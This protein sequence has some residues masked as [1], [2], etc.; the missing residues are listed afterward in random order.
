MNNP[1]DYVDGY[2]NIHG[3]YYDGYY[4]Y[5]GVYYDGY[6]GDY[7]YFAYAPSQARVSIGFATASS[8]VVSAPEAPVRI[9]GDF[10][11]TPLF[12]TINSTTNR[13]GAV[14]FTAPDNVGTFV[15]QVYGATGEHH[16]LIF[17]LRTVAAFRCCLK[18]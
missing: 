10:L 8:T 1:D 12:S 2:A 17:I 4:S 13:T 9:Q 16:I 5:Y 11:T 6:Y 3:D 18:S 14:N 7:G 15:I